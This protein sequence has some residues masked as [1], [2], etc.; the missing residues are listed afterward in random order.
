MRPEAWHSTRVDE[1]GRESTQQ[2]ASSGHNDLERYLNLSMERLRRPFLSR[3]TG[4]LWRILSKLV[5]HYL[6]WISSSGRAPSAYYALE[7]R[8]G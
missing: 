2:F 4:L 3:L 7:A 6:M 1:V 5:V 8:E